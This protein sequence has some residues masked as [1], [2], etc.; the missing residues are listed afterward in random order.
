MTSAGLFELRPGPVEMTA[1]LPPGVTAYHGDAQ[2][3]DELIQRTGAAFINGGLNAV[4]GFLTKTGRCDDF[5]PVPLQFIDVAKVF[6]P[7]PLHEELQG[8]FRKPLH[9]H[10]G[11]AA[12]VNELPDQLGGAVGIL[13]V[14]LPGAAGTL[15]DFQRP[16]TAG[17]N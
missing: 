6:D 5:G 12:E 13:A 10:T 9:L 11:L 14:K 1:Q 16:A 15:M 4:K 7:P 17:A 2:G 3:G 8:L